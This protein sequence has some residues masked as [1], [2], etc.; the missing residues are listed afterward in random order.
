MKNMIQFH[1][2][3]PLRTE[4][5]DG[6]IAL[7]TITVKVLFKHSDKIVDEMIFPEDEDDAGV[8]EFTYK[9]G[10]VMEVPHQTIQYLGESALILGN[11]VPVKPANT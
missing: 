7:V 5:S 11:T 9:S 1:E 10:L 6:D 2:L 4:P 3:P 8:V